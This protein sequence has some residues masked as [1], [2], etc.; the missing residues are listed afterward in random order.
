MRACGPIRAVAAAFLVMAA[1]SGCSGGSGEAVPSWPAGPGS[2]TPSLSGTI[3]VMAPASLKG[4]LDRAGTAF[5]RAHPGLT[6]GVNYGHIPTLFTQ[7]SQGVPGDVLVTPDEMTMMQARTKG[8][9]APAAVAVARNDLVLVVPVAN[10]AQVKDAGALG[11]A[12]L[13]V[14]VCAAELPCGR[15]TAEAAARSGVTLAADSFEPGGSPAVVTKAAAGEIDLGVSF[16]A[17]VRAGGGKVTGIP[18]ADELGAYA[19]VTAAAVESSHHADAAAAFLAFLS[20]AT[21]RAYFTEA[22]FAPL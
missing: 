4:A 18:L 21:G 16:A 17:D 3:T 5:E 15:L 20:S 13:T 19:Q 12:G 7:L 8:I 11:D 22:G 1:P 14:A 2:G 9:T 6:V 10:P